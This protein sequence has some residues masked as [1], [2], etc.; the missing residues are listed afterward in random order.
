MTARSGRPERTRC[1]MERAGYLYADAGGDR[2]GA[3]LCDGAG[4]ILYVSSNME[5]LERTGQTCL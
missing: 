2:E 4:E 5:I 3:G 1:R